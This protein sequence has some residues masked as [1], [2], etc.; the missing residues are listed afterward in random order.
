[1]TLNQLETLS[2]QEVEM[3]LYIVNVISPPCVP[4]MTFEA[5]HLTW[6][7]HDLLIKKF[8]DAFPKLRPEGHEIY[9]SM[10]LK[11][12]VEIRINQHPNPNENRT[13]T[14]SSVA[15]P[16]PSEPTTEVTGSVGSPHTASISPDEKN[17]TGSNAAGQPT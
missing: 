6:F 14:S 2:E 4:K 16:T 12:G 5:R 10:M 13:E 17:L 7:K 3:A 15:N 1:M 11:L 9:K 8:V